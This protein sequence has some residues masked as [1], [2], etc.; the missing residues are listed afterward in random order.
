MAVNESIGFRTTINDG[1]P[2]YIWFVSPGQIN[3]QVPTDA[4]TGP[5]TVTVKTSNEMAST[6]AML[7]PF[8]PSFSL[9]DGKHVAGIILRSDGSG[10]YGGGSY[11]ILGPTGSSIGYPT[12]AAKAGDSVVL[13]GVGFGPTNPPVPAGRAYSGAAP[14]TMPVGLTI[15]ETAVIPAFAGISGAGLYQVNVIVPIGLSS[16]DVSLLATAGGMF[17]PSN[18]VISLQ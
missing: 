7:A 1:L 4:K 17:T 15:G 2:A 8:A 12:V 14:V 16:G 11:D 6:S 10:A 9:L 18:V 3:L 5:V 13:F